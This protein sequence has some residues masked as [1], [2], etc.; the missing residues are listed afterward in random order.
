MTVR[1]DWPKVSD[2]IQFVAAICESKR[3]EVVHMDEFLSNIPVAGLKIETANN[4]A[5]AMMF[6]ASFARLWVALIGI[7]AHLLLCAFNVFLPGLEF[8]GKK[9]L[10]HGDVDG[11]RLS[12]IA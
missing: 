5:K 11:N 8:V 12:I 4:A 2:R 6:Q 10:P 7:Y 1:A 3:L 9:S